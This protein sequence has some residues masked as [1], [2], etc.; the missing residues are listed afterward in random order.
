LKTK[1]SKLKGEPKGDYEFHLSEKSKIK[2]KE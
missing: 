1:S 2:N